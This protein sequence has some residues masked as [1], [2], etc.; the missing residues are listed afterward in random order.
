MLAHVNPATAGLPVSKIVDEAYASHSTW[1]LEC[2]RSNCSPTI[3]CGS[4]DSRVL[5]SIIQMTRAEGATGRTRAWRRSISVGDQSIIISDFD[6][7]TGHTI[8]DF[9]PSPNCKRPDDIM[10]VCRNPA[11][12]LTAS[13]AFLP[14]FIVHESSK[15]GEFLACCWPKIA[16]H[17]AVMF[18]WH[19]R[20]SQTLVTGNDVH[21]R[22]V[23]STRY[24]SCQK[25]LTVDSGFRPS[26]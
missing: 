19:C 24:R 23:I 12:S 22:L 10:E 26:Y 20:V 9:H 18:I 11:A 1:R 6:S 25:Q 15:S 4:M 21:D 13:C 7:T 17:L 3:T 5:T 16:S 2:G 14:A 8:K